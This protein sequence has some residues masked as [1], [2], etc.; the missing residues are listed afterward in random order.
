MQVTRN[1]AERHGMLS[2]GGGKAWDA[3]L[4]TWTDPERLTPM[5]ADLAEALGLKRCGVPERYLRCSQKSW[6]PL[7]NND[8]WGALEDWLN[9]RR[10]RWS[11]TILGPTGTG[12]TH[13]ATALF[14]EFGTP[15]WWVD[16]AD[17]IHALREE[18]RRPSEVLGTRM[19]EK[20]HAPRLVLIDDLLQDRMTDFAHDEWLH[21]L[22]S[23]Y[24]HD[25][26]TII[27]SNAEELQEFDK[28]DSRVTSRLHDGVVIRLAGQ[29]QRTAG[30]RE[31]TR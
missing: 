13:L 10:G 23:R 28:L 16:A 30:P 1:D 5:N 20:L 19:A 29:D 8:P 9:G 7:R 17:A 2:S 14:R 6:R 15:G 25:W 4:G 22:N 26:P 21:A 27:T 31:K 18:V 12:K 24:N 11:V 3:N